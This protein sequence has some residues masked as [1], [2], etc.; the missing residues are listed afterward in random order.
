[1]PSLR[2][3]AYTAPYMHD[4][5]LATLDQVLEHYATGIEKS[6]TLDPLLLKDGQKGIALTADEKGKIIAFLNILNDETFIRDSRFSESGAEPAPELAQYAAT[7]WEKV[8]LRTDNPVIKAAF[9][10]A[11]GYYWGIKQGLLAEN[12]QETSRSAKLLLNLL[13]NMD[14]TSATP[15]QKAFYL[16]V[17]QD[18][19]F[20]TEHVSET[21]SV[22]HQR[23]HFGDLSKNLFRLIKSFKTNEKPLYYYSC[24][25]AANG[26]G[27]FWMSESKEEKGNPFFGKN[28]KK[29][30]QIVVTALE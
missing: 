23:D 6:P 19:G 27:G 4:G 9:T 11:L 25:K 28:D 7:D 2:N 1:M 20:D 14:L 17:H 24:P 8:D 13:E 15:L 26:M 30:G 22:A 29:C 3:L 5:R 10:K 16:K 18:L 12:G 21:E